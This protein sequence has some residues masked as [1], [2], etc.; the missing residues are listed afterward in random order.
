MPDA[1]SLATWPPRLARGW[2]RHRAR[3]QMPVAT[4]LWGSKAPLKSRQIASATL[5]LWL[6]ALLCQP[7]R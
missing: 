1:R 2:R 4:K 7:M 5:V 3:P 6:C